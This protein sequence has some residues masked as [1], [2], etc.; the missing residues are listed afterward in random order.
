MFIIIFCK[1]PNITFRDFQKAHQS[2]RPSEEV[3]SQACA[4]ISTDVSA[5]RARLK[6]TPT[7]KQ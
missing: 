1:F 3:D 7:K 2:S 4:D 6:E 5:A